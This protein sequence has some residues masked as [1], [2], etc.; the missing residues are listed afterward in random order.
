[1]TQEPSQ[2]LTGRPI[3][4]QA[5]TYRYERKFVL[6][7]QSLADFRM[8][9][10][11]HPEMFRAAYPPR[12]VNNLYF[13]TLDLSSLADNIEGVCNRT[14]MRVRWYGEMVGDIP[15]PFLEFKIKRGTVGTKRRF[16]LP[17]ISVSKDDLATT[18]AN[19]LA[20]AGLPAQVAMQFAHVSPTLLNRY[21]REYFQSSQGFRLTI[22]SQIQSFDPLPRIH[23]ARTHPEIVIELKYDRELEPQAA[24]LLSH[25]GLR[26]M[27][28]S[29]Y[30]AGLWI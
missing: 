2:T 30:V 21:Y 6:D 20:T 24:T 29:K 7:W 1:M 16:D 27:K 19:S 14:K 26:V 18:V 17:S 4:G 11:L 3:D 9:L 22:D 5:G 12:Y 25:L 15:S 10:K 23:A 13:D 8:S 28:N